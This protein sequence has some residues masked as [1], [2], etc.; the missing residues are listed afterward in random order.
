[1]A[2]CVCVCV[3][4]CVEWI[5]LAQNRGRRW[6]LM[7][8]VMDLGVLAPWSCLVGQLAGCIVIAG[9]LVSWLIRLF[10]GNNKNL[11]A[12]TPEGEF[13]CSYRY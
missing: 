3:C 12:E 4:V 1:L 8:T 5:D 2:G 13:W 7:N 11:R 10:L 6:A 9:K